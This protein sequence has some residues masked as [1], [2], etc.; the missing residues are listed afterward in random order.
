M[1]KILTVE[2]LDFPKEIHIGNQDTTINVFAK[3]EFHKLDMQ[4]EMEYCLHVFVYDIH[5]QIDPPIIISNWD[6]SYVISVATAL[7]RKDD[8]I[9]EANII[10][11]ATSNETNL[12]I[13]VMLKLGSVNTKETYFSRNLKVFV[14]ATPAIGRVSMWSSPHNTRVFY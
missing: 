8:F 2:V 13:P 6:E 1:A 11:K 14:T 7:D 9:G 12:K 5:D 4:Y 10:I 3:I